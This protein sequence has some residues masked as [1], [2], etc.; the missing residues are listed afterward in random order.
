MRSEFKVGD[1]V[2]VVSKDHPPL[3][4]VIY[5]LLTN[6][7]HNDFMVDHGTM[8]GSRPGIYEEKQ[9]QKLAVYQLKELPKEEI[10][11]LLSRVQAA[12]HNKS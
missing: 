1:I 10:I 8:E 9:L 5:N 2:R 12:L 11:A 4:G 6:K 3:Y 7:N